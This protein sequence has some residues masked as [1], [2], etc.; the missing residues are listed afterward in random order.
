MSMESMEPFESAENFNEDVGMFEAAAHPTRV[1][2]TVPVL[3]SILVVQDG[4]SQDATAMGFAEAIASRCGAALEVLSDAENA[5][6]I[7]ARAGRSSTQMVVL[8]VPF[9]QNY[10]ELAHDS[11]GAVVDQLLLKSGGPVLCIREPQDPAQIQQALHDVIVPIVTSDELASKAV[12]WGFLL[13]PSGGRLDLVAIADRSDLE[14]ARH[15]V[16]EDVRTLDADHLSRAMMKE[17]GGLVS[18]TQQRGSAEGRTIHVETR[19][20]PF[21]ATTLRELHERPHMLI[22]GISHQHS[23]PSFHRATDLLLESK[24]AVLFV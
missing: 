5:E 1:K 14:V 6:Q 23:S 20:G 21:V 17:I 15:L 19:V 8:P 2:L 22:C 24:G 4:S 18:A 13:T 9:G 16:S 12:S 10:D 7:L 3:K 11:L